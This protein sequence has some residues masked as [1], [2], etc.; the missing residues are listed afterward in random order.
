MIINNFEGGVIKVVGRAYSHQEEISGD[1]L[2]RLY[3]FYKLYKNIRNETDF[4][5]ELSENNVE[6]N[7]CGLFSIL[8]GR[9]NTPPSESFISADLL[10]G[11]EFL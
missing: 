3:Y 2:R 10:A 9:R 11:P 6:W 8:T 4:S 5:G 7:S 1:T